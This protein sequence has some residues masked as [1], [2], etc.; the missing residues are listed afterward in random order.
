ME[1]SIRLYTQSMSIFVKATPAKKPK[2][3]D[4]QQ[5]AYLYA[6]I[7]VVFVVTQ[8]FTFSDFLR[9]L[10]SFWLPGGTTIAYLLGGI[11]VVSEVFALPFLLGMSLSPLMRV[12][13]MV[14]GWLVALIWIKLALWL[15]LTVN[16]VSNIGYFGT[17]IR[18]TPGWWAVFFG[19]ALGILTAWASW[20]M[21]PFVT[22][23]K[24]K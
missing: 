2:T 10:E 9:L 11:I 19:I 18:L 1:R 8:L 4:A 13:S 16:A 23:R 12:V 15:M 24:S 6:F 21:W 3:R 22:K 7:L 17:M 14:L 5:I 20:G